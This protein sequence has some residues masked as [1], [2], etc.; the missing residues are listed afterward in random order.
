MRFGSFLIILGDAVVIVLVFS[1]IGEFGFGQQILSRYPIS[2]LGW[3]V[4]GVG[5]IVSGDLLG[6]RTKKFRKYESVVFW[7]VLGGILIIGGILFINRFFTE[8]VSETAELLARNKEIRALMSSD[9]NLVETYTRAV[10]YETRAHYR[11]RFYGLFS[12]IIGG[13]MM[14]YGALRSVEERRP[15]S[16]GFLSHLR[17]GFAHILWKLSEEVGQEYC[18]HCGASMPVV[19][20]FCMKCG[21]PQE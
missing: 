12:M 21:K 10:E 18:Y 13:G 16:R 17:M 19:A 8:P 6:G 1:L 7:C 3:L 2:A 5:L 11:L 14:T 4:I 9:P 15:K 20:K